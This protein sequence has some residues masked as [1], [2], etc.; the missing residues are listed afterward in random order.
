MADALKINVNNGMVR[1]FVRS[2]DTPKILGNPNVMVN[3]DLSGVTIN[4]FRLWRVE[5]IGTDNT[6][7][8][9]GT[10]RDMTAQEITQRE[11]RLKQ[12]QRD[13]IDDDSQQ[14][15]RFR[16]L[17]FVLEQQTPGTRAAYRTKLKELR[18]L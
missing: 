1:D 3:P 9:T 11:N 14:E 5:N 8:A 7:N 13:A 16:A 10:V 6:G 4:D 17:L 12:D 2:V 15:D 18:N